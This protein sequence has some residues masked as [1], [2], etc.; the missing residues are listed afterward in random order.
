[1]SRYKL[2]K[3]DLDP[4]VESST[5]LT[6]S[7]DVAV[8]SDQTS[9]TSGYISEDANLEHTISSLW[10]DY[11]TKC[12]FTHQNYFEEMQHFLK[13]GESLFTCPI[14]SMTMT[15]TKSL[16][17]L[18]LKYQEIMKIVDDLKVEKLT[19]RHSRKIGVSSDS[20]TYP[21][22]SMVIKALFGDPTEKITTNSGNIFYLNLISKAI[23]MVD[24]NIYKILEDLPENLA[25]LCACN[26]SNI[27]FINELFQ[28]SSKD[29][30]I[31]KKFFQAK[32]GGASEVEVLSLGYTVLSTEI[33]TFVQT[34]MTMQLHTPPINSKTISG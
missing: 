33:L 5:A 19:M 3:L 28:C 26:D 8:L 9:I 31:S 6:S 32:L 11:L 10:D 25:L 7:E 4:Q 23:T 13:Q 16:E 18:R 30:F 12:T 27:F 21:W 24:D 1:M 15:T 17:I 14:H 29:D 34:I 22:M 20:P 2:K